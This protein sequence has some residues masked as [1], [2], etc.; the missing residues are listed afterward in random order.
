M[1]DFQVIIEYF[2]RMCLAIILGGIIGYERETQNKAVGLRDTMLICLGATAI[3]L[4]T[5]N[6]IETANANTISFD[7]SRSITYYLVALGFIGG[8]I[9]NKYKNK[10]E[11][12][13]T[14][15]LLLPV[16]IL[17]FWCGLGNYVLAVML[18]LF[19]LF[20]LKLKYFRIQIIKGIKRRCRKK[21]K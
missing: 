4:F 12:I 3:T 9:V 6:L 10:I 15:S 17:G 19:I 8:G 21:K 7:L 20:I 14:G 5:L 1:I 13:T 18:A 2:I 16:A 11:G